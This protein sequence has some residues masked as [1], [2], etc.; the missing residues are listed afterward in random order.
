MDFF[1]R[2][3]EKTILRVPFLQKILYHQD[4]LKHK[5]DIQKMILKTTS[6]LGMMILVLNGCSSDNEDEKFEMI[7]GSFPRLVDVPNRPLVP[8]NRPGESYFQNKEMKLVEIREEAY[9]H[10][11]KNFQQRKDLKDIALIEDKE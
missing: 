2:E 9:K 3:K 8:Q 4:K 11:K 7:P 1:C 6:L 10:K 5:V